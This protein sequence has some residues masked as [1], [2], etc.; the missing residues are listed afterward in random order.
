[1]NATISEG[2]LQSIDGT[3]IIPRAEVASAAD[4]GI[5]DTGTP[6]N[7][8]HGQIAIFHAPSVYV[9]WRRMLSVE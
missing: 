8:D 5:I 2:V 7:N 4:T 3:R 6:A 9:G 1:M